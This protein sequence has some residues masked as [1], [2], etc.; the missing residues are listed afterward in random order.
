MID[1]IYI[2]TYGRADKQITFK[3]LPKKYQEKVFFVL[4]PEEVNLFREY[5]K[6]I[7]EEKDFGIAATRRKVAEVSQNIKYC[8]LDDDLSFLYTRRE[9]EEG[10]SNQPMSEQQFDDMFNLMD[11]V[12]DYYTFG[13][14]EA[15][16]NPPVRD[17]DFKVC[18]RPSGNVFYNGHKLPFDK[19]DWTDLKVSEDYNVA[20]QLLTMGHENKISLRYRV[21]T[22]MTAKPGGCEFERTI[23]DH[24]NSMKLLKNKFPQFVDLYEKEANDGFKGNK[25]AARISWKKAYESSQVNT[26]DNFL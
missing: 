17:K 10:K 2:L 26:L 3:N 5:N 7:L 24:N 4:R 18:G 23:A 15:T 13:G 20:L 1:K 6:V 16:W 12:L 21:D 9:N 25:L 19:I 22:G 14:L 11:N 8:M